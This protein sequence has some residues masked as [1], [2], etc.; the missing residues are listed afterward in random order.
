MSVTNLFN[1][2]GNVIISKL[3]TDEEFYNNFIDILNPDYFSYE[4]FVIFNSYLRYYK[5]YNDRPILYQTELEF[6]DTTFHSN[7]DCSAANNFID[8]LKVLQNLKLNEQ[9]VYDKANHFIRFK[10]VESALIKSVS[11][12]EDGDSNDGSKLED[13]PTILQNAL[14][15]GSQSVGDDYIGGCVDRY[16]YFNQIINRRIPFGLKTFDLITNGGLPPKSLNLV[17][18]PPGGSKSIFLCNYAAN[19]LRNGFNVVYITLEMS[20]EHIGQRIDS[21]L[22][23][24]DINEVFNL[25]LEE[26]VSRLNNLKNNG[27]GNLYIREYPISSANVNDFN[28][29]LKQLKTKHS[30]I[31]DVV[32]I[33]YLNICA[34]T[35]G[36]SSSLG[37]YSIVKNIAEE[38]RSCATIN[39]IPILS[40]VQMNRTGA[41]SQNK[42][43]DMTNLADSFG[44]GMVADF[45]VALVCKD[46]TPTIVNCTQIKNRYHDVRHNNC[47]NV[48]LSK[49][50]MRFFDLPDAQTVSVYESLVE[51]ANNTDIMDL[52][53]LNTFNGF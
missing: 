17:V 13:I 18:A 8:S 3:Y 35:K 42:T 14:S 7:N 23:D 9:W 52:N 24:T 12:F 28:S 22:L 32:I 36:N 4:C 49:P 20:S 40:A 11:I 37:S 53:T 26:Y 30:F 10:A 21:N 34:S 47:F 15:V 46:D 33:D 48:G 38:I 19:C 50:K 31:P 27:L 6:S 25:P 43:P 45:I 1:Y 51:Y 2:T 41:S 29:F 44:I 5:E 39:D 16:N